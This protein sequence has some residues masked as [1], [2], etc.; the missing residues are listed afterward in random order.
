[1]SQLKGRVALVTGGSRGI[2][3]A[4][5][6]R[7]AEQGAHVY[8]NYSSGKEAAEETVRMCEAAGGTAEIIGFTVADSAGVDQAFDAIRAK[9]QKLDILVNN[10]GI[11]HDGLFMRMKDEEWHKVIDVNLTGCFYCARAATKMMMKARYGRIINIS[12]IVGEMG[13]AGQVPYVSSKAGLIG[14]T[15]AIAREMASRNITV[16]AITPGF[17]ETEMTE[18][19]D[20]KVRTHHMSGIPLARFGSADDVAAAVAFLAGDGA[21][22]ITG[23]VLG[24]NGG[25]YM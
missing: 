22:Y 11:A 20:E 1:M 7:L 16:N 3:R 24:V 25:M 19:L 9:S 13:N 8:V 23:Q 17:I 6:V 18:Q 14:M 5:S 12:S 10:A 15:K 4:I 21:S 2:G